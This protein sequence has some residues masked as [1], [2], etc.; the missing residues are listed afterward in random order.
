MMTPGTAILGMLS[1]LFDVMFGGMAAA[2][3]GG[4][5]AASILTLFV[6]PVAYYAIYRIK[7]E[8]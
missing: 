6:L 7:G 3:V 2:I 1:L 5:L 8:Q 4:L